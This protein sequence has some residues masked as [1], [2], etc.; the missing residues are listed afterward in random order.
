[1][2]VNAR[3]LAVFLF[4]A[5]VLA[6]NIV[7]AQIS[8]PMFPG[9]GMSSQ[10]AA[11][12]TAA[13][14]ATDTSSQSTY[15]FAG[16]SFGTAAT[17][18]YT[19]CA[20]AVRNASSTFTVNSMTINGISAT[21]VGSSANNTGATVQNTAAMF[22]AAN[23]TG[24]S[25]TVSYVLSTTANRAAVMC[26]SL[27]NLVSATPTANATSIANAPTASLTIN[28]NGV[29][30]AAVMGSTSPFT[31]PSSTWSNLTK[32]FDVNIGGI[33]N[34]SGASLASAAGQSA[35][36]TDTITNVVGSASAAVF[37]AFR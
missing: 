10:P 8:G 27:T 32:D 22:I 12:I 29:G 26:W 14:S 19:L 17:N 3:V 25:G 16:V 4:C 31:S 34:S 21:Q 13:G 11:T 5:T 18:R 9:P 15:S 23:P 28:A 1:M 35:T 20:A 36:V 7:Y 2:T 33:N 24:T 6:A 30:V 37:L